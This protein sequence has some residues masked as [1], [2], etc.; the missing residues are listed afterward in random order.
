LL[1]AEIVHR[2]NREP[3]FGR[4]KHQKIFHLCEHIAQIE[5]INGQYYREAAGPLDTSHWIKLEAIA[6]M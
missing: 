2:L 1:S 5:E 3:P 4:I 6:N